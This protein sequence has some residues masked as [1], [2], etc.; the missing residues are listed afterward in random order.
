M[1]PLVAFTTEHVT[2]LTGLSPR[3]LRYWEETGVFAASYINEDPHRPY[4][5]LY[6]FR[7]V[8]GLRTLAILRRTYRVEL[9]ELRRV[10]QYLTQHQDAPWAS[11]RFRVSGRHVVFPD[12]AS[13]VP[14]SGKPWR[15]AVIELDLEDIAR[16]VETEAARLRERTPEDYG[17]ITR[18]RYVNH[19][20]RV[21][22]GTRIPTSAIWNFYEDG[23]DTEAIIAEYPQLRAED[24][25]AA[26]AHERHV[27][28]Q[29]AA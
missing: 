18:H 27:R 15:Q 4:R 16:N 28:E 29:R 25:E 7:D 9:D 17:R 3:V 14:V 8:V 1:P 20:A 6:S 13:G 2:R 11:M 12:P 22:S 21:I 23:Y 19:N 24:I 10:G 5:R 26:I